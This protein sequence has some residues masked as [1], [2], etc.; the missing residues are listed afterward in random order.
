MFTMT[1]AAG[2]RLAQKLENKDGDATMRFVRDDERGGWSVRLGTAAASDVAFDYEGRKVLVLDPHA[3]QL[4]RNKVLD[5]KETDE[6]PRLR[7]Y[8]R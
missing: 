5:I 1:K 8:G 4:L 7:L 6:G 2:A 3:S